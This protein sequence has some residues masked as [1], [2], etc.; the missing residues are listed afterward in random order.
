M[1][2]CINNSLSFPFRPSDQ[3]WNGHLTERIT[4]SYFKV[5]SLK[6]E[7]LNL[8]KNGKQVICVLTQ[9]FSDIIWKAGNL[10]H[11]VLGTAS[12]ISFMALL[13][14]HPYI[15]FP[16]QKHPPRCP[17]TRIP[18][19]ICIPNLADDLVPWMQAFPQTLV[20]EISFRQLVS[21]CFLGFNYH[22]CI[23]DWIQ[24]LVHD[25]KVLYY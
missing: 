1:A 8:E 16:S 18:C 21:F 19:A 6:T 25:R 14:P 13:A 7:M 10:F 20:W 5:C 15:F 4:K 12:A 3:I 24:G 2:L 23:A 11:I 9:K 22:S 17:Q